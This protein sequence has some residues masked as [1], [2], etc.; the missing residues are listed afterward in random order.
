MSELGPED[1]RSPVRWQFWNTHYASELKEIAK[2]M[3]R[4]LDSDSCLLDHLCQWEIPSGRISASSGLFDMFK[5]SD[6]FTTP[7]S[8]NGSQ[9]SAI[10]MATICFGMETS[11]STK[12]LAWRDLLWGDETCRWGCDLV[13]AP[14]SNSANQQDYEQARSALERWR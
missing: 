8:L 13:K 6:R 2:T 5:A 11:T 9:Q 1:N 7:S 10:H 12:P 3:K 14:P 4:K